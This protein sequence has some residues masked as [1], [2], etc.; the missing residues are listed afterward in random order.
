MPEEVPLACGLCELGVLGG[1]LAGYQLAESVRAT[2]PFRTGVI[3]PNLGRPD[4]LQ[5]FLRERPG[6]HVL[7]SFEA[8]EALPDCERTELTKVRDWTFG[9]HGYGLYIEG[10]PDS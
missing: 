10:T 9:R 8:F 3:L 2:V 7:M 5:R 6:A 1:P 4:D